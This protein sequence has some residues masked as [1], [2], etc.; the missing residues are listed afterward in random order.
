MSDITENERLVR[1]FISEFYSSETFALEHIASTSFTFI[2]DGGKKMN[3]HQYAE[4]KDLMSGYCQLVFEMPE[5]DDNVNFK[6][7]FKLV[8]PQKDKAELHGTGII[9][10]L[11]KDNLLEEVTVDYDQTGNNNK[12]IQ[13][14]I[15]TSRD[16]AQKATTKERDVIDF[17]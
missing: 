9:T 3:F 5:S 11:V 13:S 17:L 1:Y 16:L 12:T 14:A 10:F 7:S 6:S 2:V 4:R 8:A 15:L